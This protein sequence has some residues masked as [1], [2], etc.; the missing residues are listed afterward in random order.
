MR[1][2][3][4]P[5]PS[6]ESHRETIEKIHKVYRVRTYGNGRL[7]ELVKREFHTLVEDEA[8]RPEP[9]AAHVAR[10]FEVFLRTQ[11]MGKVLV[12]LAHLEM[13]FAYHVEFSLLR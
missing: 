3:L 11:L 2:I 5:L 7:R 4:Q 10:A 12:I 1:G 9:T 8:K 6:K 13:L